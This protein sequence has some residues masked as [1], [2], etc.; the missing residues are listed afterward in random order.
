MSTV[1]V[2]ASPPTH[3]WDTKIDNYQFLGKLSCF[4]DN[5]TG[6][7]AMLAMAIEGNVDYTRRLNA[8]KAG[9]NSKTADTIKGY[10]SACVLTAQSTCNKFSQTVLG[11]KNT[12]VN[13]AAWSQTID[14]AAALAKKTATD[15]IDAAS[16][17]AKEFIKKLPQDSRGAA[18]D[19]FVAGTKVVL[20]FFSTVWSK[21]KEV[22][23]N[24][25]QFLKG[26]WNVVQSA[27]GAVLGAA[28]L[29]L[30]YIKGAAGYQ[31]IVMPEVD[32][33]RLRLNPQHYDLVDSDAGTSL[34]EL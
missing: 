34:T 14:Q 20:N 3:S 31:A 7:E 29:A 27:A 21:I 6:S 19:L 12:E 32:L 23:A 2:W 15:A 13:E 18:A 8:Y 10:N 9:N 28:R 17:K 30:N 33:E 26:V 22:V 25:A 5:F 4:T 16:N 1:Q 11:L 24:I